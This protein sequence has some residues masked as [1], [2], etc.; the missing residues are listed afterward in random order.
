MIVLLQ[1]VMEVANHSILFVTLNNLSSILLLG[2]HFLA[3]SIDLFHLIPVDL[4]LNQQRDQNRYKMEP[5]NRHKHPIHDP[6]Q[7]NQLSVLL[8][9]F[10]KVNQTDEKE[11]FQRLTQ[12]K[13][14]PDVSLLKGL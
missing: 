11:Q 12:I 2:T 3:F 9:L 10:H 14:Y 5:K 4:P 1:D 8:I 13:V 7:L 6:R